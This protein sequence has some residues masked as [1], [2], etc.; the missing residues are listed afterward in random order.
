MRHIF[1]QLLIFQVIS[2]GFMVT[3]SQRPFHGDIFDE[4]EGPQARQLAA[5]ATVFHTAGFAA[6]GLL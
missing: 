2:R 6:G 1:V 5:L 3:A 4:S